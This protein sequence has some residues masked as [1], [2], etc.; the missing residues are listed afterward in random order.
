M[1]A[2]AVYPLRR[3]I[4]TAATGGIYAAPTNDPLGCCNRKVA[5]GACL[6]PT[7]QCF[8]P[9]RAGCSTSLECARAAGTPY[10]LF[11]IYYL[12]FIFS[13][14]P[15]Y[16]THSLSFPPCFVQSGQN[17]HFTPKNMCNILRKT[18]LRMGSL[19]GT[20]KLCKSAILQV[21]PEQNL[22]VCAKRRGPVRVLRTDCKSL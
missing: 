12:L 1:L 13:S 4:G 8:L 11:I 10:L 14:S 21:R 18:S 20:I 6:A 3:I 17:A 9:R 7:A 19:F 22:D 2:R 16:R 5:G 15:L